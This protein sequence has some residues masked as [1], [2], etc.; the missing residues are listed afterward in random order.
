MSLSRAASKTRLDAADGL[1]DG[2]GAVGMGEPLIALALGAGSN[3][4]YGK[5]GTFMFFG[6]T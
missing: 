2:L 4:R 3:G 6:K 5:K 1:A